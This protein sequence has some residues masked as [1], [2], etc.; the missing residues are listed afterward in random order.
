MGCWMGEKLPISYSRR[1]Q[2][3]VRNDP[4]GNQVTSWPFICDASVLWTVTA[5]QT[6]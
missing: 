5:I 2:L 1:H 6:N 3:R 4:T